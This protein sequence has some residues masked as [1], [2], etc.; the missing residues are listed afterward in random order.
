LFAHKYVLKLT[1]SIVF[2]AATFIS[3]MVMTRYSGEAYGLMV[4]GMS[5]VATVNA[6]LGMGLHLTNTK[7]VAEQNEL[8]ACVS[9]AFAIRAGL[10]AIMVIILLTFL[11][12]L[13]LIGEGLSSVMMNIVLIFIVYFVVDGFRAMV[14]STFTGRMEAGKE[15]IVQMSECVVRVSL[16]IIFALTGASAVL[17]S[18]SY[19]A[20]AMVALFVGFMFFGRLGVRL[21]YPRMAREYIKF[22]IPLALPIS[23]V[24]M[25]L[26]VDKAIIGA[27]WGSMEVAYYTAAYGLF[28]AFVMVG[29]VMSTLV[30]SHMS[31][32]HSEGKK[33]SM[34]STLWTSQ[35]YLA[36]FLLPVTVFL[37]IFGDNVAGILFGGGFTASG[38]VISVLALAIYPMTLGNIMSSVLLSTNRNVSY[39][40]ISMIYAVSVLIMFVLFIPR[41]LFGIPLFGLGGVGAALSFLIGSLLLFTMVSLVLK[42]EETV[43]NHPKLLLYV[44]AA[45]AVGTVLYVI[46]EEFVFLGVL[47][48]VALALMTLLMYLGIL[49]LIKE[50]TMKDLRFIMDTFNPRNLYHDL[51]DEMKNDVPYMPLLAVRAK[52]R[53]FFTDPRVKRMEQNVSI[54][55]NSVRRAIMNRPFKELEIDESLDSI[56]A[57]K[58]KGDVFLF[59]GDV[60]SF[61]KG[62]CNYLSDLSKN[63][64]PDK[65]FFV[66]ETPWIDKSE[67]EGRM[68][69][70][71]IVV[72]Y[73][74]GKGVIPKNVERP[75]EGVVSGD[76]MSKPYMRAAADNMCARFPK[77]NCDD[78]ESLSLWAHVYFSKMMEILAPKKM[79]LWNKFQ[80]LHQIIDGIAKD[81]G[82]P[83]LYMEFGIIPGTFS[84]ESE[85]QMGESWPAKNAEEFR[86][87]RIS[88]DDL[89]LADTIL[90][91]LRE[92]KLNRNIQPR[93]DIRYLKRHLNNGKPTVLYCGHN[94]YES[95][96]L[97]YTYDSIADHSPVFESSDSAAGS[98]G[99]LALKN[100]WNLLYKPHPIMKRH[101]T[102]PTS[103]INVSGDDINDLIDMADVVVT[104]LSQTAYISLIREKPVVMLGYIQLMDKGCTYE[105][106]TESELEG[107]IEQALSDGLTEDM[108]E[109][110]AKHVAQAVKYYVFDDMNK[111]DMRY[112]R[113]TEEFRDVLRKDEKT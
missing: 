4:W 11:A 34:H 41:S 95:G 39:G 9:A 109:N 83:V 53:M 100:E 8:G 37:V 56:K 96:M 44:I 69:V 73:I 6:A 72:P 88:D 60:L 94:D 50:F 10:S 17:L 25:I 104:I 33:D 22:T 43:R 14:E 61:D 91:F 46:R 62:V 74:F 63:L 47:W 78:M 99:E 65:L 2:S 31:K 57:L 23:M 67:S 108:K 71:T 54:F 59:F 51:L 70:S 75:G 36:A 38:P 58:I 76:T 102:V 97:P 45:L 64:R 21:K 16:L 113:D 111:R 66:S 49:A 24:A 40:R 84:L 42:K 12:V 98:L 93:S 1:A 15:A 82:I 107:V 48:Y 81:M 55:V 30:L 80:P 92:S 110:F 68:P 85:G 103:A 29:T 7:K 13:S 87:L 19:L 35:R 86:D 101:S 32:L 112:G 28:F 52:L 90:D 26:F 5:I 18:L 3:L 77:A 20:G 105:A 106:F 27:F 89:R 79:I